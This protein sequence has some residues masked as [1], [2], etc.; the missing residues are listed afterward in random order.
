M[1][2]FIDS[3]NGLGFG[4]GAL[5]LTVDKNG[6]LLGPGTFSVSGGVDF[7]GDGIDD[8]TGTLLTGSVTAFGPGPSPTTGG[9]WEFDG[10]VSLTGGAVTQSP[11][12]LSG[13]GLFTNL[14]VPGSTVAFDL[15]AEQQLAG[16]IGI[17]GDFAASFSGDSIKG[18]DPG[19]LL[20]PEP[21]TALMVL[22]V[23]ATAV[24]ARRLRGTGA[25]DRSGSSA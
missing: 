11:I 15:V 21:N 8:T 4:S 19:A 5:D 16:N 3:G 9:D 14:F 20:T 17:L 25:R 1:S 24:G 6:N 23:L 18:L 7:D 12:S 13:G 22:M 2:A 10:L